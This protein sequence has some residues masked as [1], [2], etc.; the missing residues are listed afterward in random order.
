M[1]GTHNY[2]LE[3]VEVRVLHYNENARYDPEDFEPYLL[4]DLSTD[5]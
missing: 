2:K 3:P 4:T 1:P 5:T